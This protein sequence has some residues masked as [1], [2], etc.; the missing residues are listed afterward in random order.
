MAGLGFC[1]KSLLSQGGGLNGVVWLYDAYD[2]A[3]QEGLIPPT[4]LH[5]KNS[6]IEHFPN[7][8]GWGGFLFFI[9]I[10]IVFTFYFVANMTS[11][12]KPIDPH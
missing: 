6:N 9:L 7:M 8:V 11:L 2:Q 10:C 1:S 3:A 5:T 4:L 12:G